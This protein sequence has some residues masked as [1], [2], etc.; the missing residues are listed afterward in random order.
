[1]Y[2]GDLWSYNAEKDV[3]VVSPK[4]DVTVLD[5]DK[6]HC[7]V[8][9]ATDGLWHVVQPA[10]AVDTVACLASDM[11]VNDFFSNTAYLQIEYFSIHLLEHNACGINITGK[12]NNFV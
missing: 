6:S 10:Q 8:I 5:I 2:A 11:V 1:M 3:Y 7:F 12:F 9:L 4:P